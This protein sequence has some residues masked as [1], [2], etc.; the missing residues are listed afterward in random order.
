MIMADKP[1]ANSPDTRT[2][3]AICVGYDLNMEKTD[4]ALLYAG[5]ALRYWGVELAYRFLI[6]YCG[7][8]YRTVYDFNKL[9]RLLG[10]TEVL[11][12]MEQ[13]GRKSI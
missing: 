10:F 9:L 13:G 12:S 1:A 11:G 8:E 7:S 6:D 4:Y 2:V 5:R 3:L